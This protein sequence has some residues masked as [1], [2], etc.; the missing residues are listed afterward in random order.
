LHT[1]RCS[2]QQ[3][4]ELD[5]SE[6]PSL[7]DLKCSNNQ[8]ILLNVKGLVELKKI[9]CEKNR[10]TKLDLSSNI[11]LERLSFPNNPLTK[12]IGLEKLRKSLTYISTADKIGDS[13]ALKF[14][15]KELGDNIDEATR[16]LKNYKELM[17]MKNASYQKINS[18]TELFN[19]DERTKSED[20]RKIYEK[21]I[22]E[23]KVLT[24]NK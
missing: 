11:K 17:T 14:L 6:C 16:H 7:K 1:L 20:I 22:A 8:L 12:I 15:D 2:S 21:Q 10:I 19:S 13:E 5:V 18:R 3:L 24:D 4:T 9:N 23:I